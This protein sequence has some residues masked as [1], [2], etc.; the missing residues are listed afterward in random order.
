MKQNW[1][2][3]LFTCFDEEKKIHF[4]LTVHYKPALFSHNTAVTG[5][6]VTPAW[7][8][9][10]S[11]LFVMKMKALRFRV[12]FHIITVWISAPSAHLSS[13]VFEKLSCFSS[14]PASHL[15]QYWNK[16]KSWKHL[17]LVCSFFTANQRKR[18]HTHTQHTGLCSYSLKSILPCR[19]TNTYVGCINVERPFNCHLPWVLHI[20]VVPWCISTI[21][22]HISTS[23]DFGSTL[24]LL[25]H[26]SVVSK[27]TQQDFSHNF[28][29]GNR[30]WR[31]Q[32]KIWWTCQSLDDAS[33]I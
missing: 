25:K 3:A 28:A 23:I 16:K 6:H 32:T 4:K 30:F 31:P 17:M 20:D 10:P 12:L 5:C 2:C 9:C 18:A 13:Q 27:L 15:F 19:S 24:S 26:I 29:V 22:V 7:P 11:W 33:W 21:S 8:A 14:F 1:K